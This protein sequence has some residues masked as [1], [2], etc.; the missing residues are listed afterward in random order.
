ML[1]HTTGLL[2]SVVVSVFLS[3]ATAQDA[4]KTEKP[5]FEISQVTLS[6]LEFQ[7]PF[8]NNNHDGRLIFAGQPT[9][10]QLRDFAML[11]GKV[12]MNARTQPE[13]DRL[14]F[15]EAA[16]CKEL[17]LVYAHIPVTGSKITVAE[18]FAL[19]QLLA[20]Q[21][22]PVL[23]HC[24]SGSRAAT[25][26][27]LHLIATNQMTKNQ[28]MAHALDMG[29]SPSSVPYFQKALM[30][31]PQRAIAA[32]DTARVIDNVHYL[33]AFG[34][35]HTLS[36]TKSDTRG[37]G[38]A[39]RWVFKAFEESIAGHNKPESTAPF[40]T[41]DSHTVE[42]DGRRILEPVE[43]VNVLCTIPGSNPEATNRLYYVLAHL[44]SRASDIMDS[45]SEAPGA[46][47]DASGVATLIELARVLSKENLDSTIVLMATSGE[48]QGLYGAKLHAADLIA[49]NADV[50]AVL[51]NDTIGDPEG[52]GDQDGSKEVRIFSEGLG[53]DL[54]NLDD[55]AQLKAALNKL[56]STGS[57]SDSPSRQLAR[58]IAFVGKLHGELPVK[59]KLIFRPD[60]YL[61]G[62]DHTPFNQLGF[63][64]VRFCEVYENYDHQ[65]QDV[66][67]EGTTQFGD[68]ATFVDAQY[69]AGVTKL[70]TAVLVHIANAPSAPTNARIITADL[71]NDT[72]LR[73][74]ASPESDTA[75][76]EVLWRKTTDH[77]WTK[78]K[79]VGDVTEATIDLSKDNWF[80]AV[81]AYDQEG[82]RSPAAYPTSAR[83]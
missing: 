32:V 57:E 36:D 20:E 55:P 66:R 58:Y 23:M 75:G 19:T 51:N 6:P 25:I 26:Y 42:P 29:M 41:F 7:D 10:Q 49:N 11:G 9:E 15:D 71:T 46:N 72:T 1:N 79:D 54:V 31:T 45:T 62:G 22:G 78:F 69:L 53:L 82:Y 5:R 2:A 73:W 33:T 30:E 65:H 44:D 83:E 77:D 70:N 39:R 17:G 38:A 18:P 40:V 34:T 74:T 56:R 81:R 59:P 13:M 14:K 52:S 24:R 50:R 68:L 67:I 48:E 4:E 27:G 3:S 43:I 80:F 35:R 64:A 47:D 63:A 28:A 60:R 8:A 16:L 76:Y 37:I 12:V 61:R 21:S